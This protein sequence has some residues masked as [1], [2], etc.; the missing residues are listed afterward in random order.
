MH[1]GHGRMHP[2][3]PGFI[4]SS[5]DNRAFALPSDDY[6]FAAELRIIALLHRSI[7]RVHVDMDDFSHSFLATILFPIGHDS[8]ITSS[9][10]ENRGAC[11]T[12]N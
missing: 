12:R 3:V 5:A 2:E 10:M 6:R 8:E 9:V 1:C 11:T 7:K 4:R